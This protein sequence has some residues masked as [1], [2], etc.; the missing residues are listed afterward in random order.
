MGETKLC[1]ESS[2]I[3]S[4]NKRRKVKNNQGA[5]GFAVHKGTVRLV[6]EDETNTPDDLSVDNV[7]SFYL[8]KHKIRN[9]DRKQKYNITKVLIPKV[10]A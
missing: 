5:F 2:K 1:K 10:L 4:V 9:G 7:H 3:G 8:G 6:I